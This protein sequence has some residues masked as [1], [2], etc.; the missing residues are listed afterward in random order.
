MCLE[1]L[2]ILGE[3]HCADR[4]AMPLEHLPVRYPKPGWSCRLKPTLA[5]CRPTRTPLR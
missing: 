1:T 4:E 2:T 5:C 3:R